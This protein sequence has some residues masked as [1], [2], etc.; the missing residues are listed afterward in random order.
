MLAFLSSL[1][2]AMDKER[3]TIIIY[4]KDWDDDGV[5]HPQIVAEVSV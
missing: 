2:M 1:R 4:S 3:T 5:M